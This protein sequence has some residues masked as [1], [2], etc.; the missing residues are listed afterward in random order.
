MP[1]ED[2]PYDPTEDLE[3][4]INVLSGI[5]A[6]DGVD[7]DQPS[8]EDELSTEDSIMRNMNT[9]RIPHRLAEMFA[10]MRPSL[11]TKNTH[12]L[13]GSGVSWLDKWVIH[14]ISRPRW[15]KIWP[16]L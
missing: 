12:Y 13:L 6:D 8:P 5:D 11:M 15:C 2:P 3:D 16:K 10:E 7:P 4:V 14:F 9:Q 1:D